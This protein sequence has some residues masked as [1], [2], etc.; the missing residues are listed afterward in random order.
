MSDAV[1]TYKNTLESRDKAIRD[2]WVK[3]MEARLV[4]EELQKCH[5][6]EGVNHYQSCK[7]LAEKYIDLLKDAK[8]KGFTTIDS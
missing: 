6:F 4:R 7:E 8:V 3:T 5:K 2:S 1:E